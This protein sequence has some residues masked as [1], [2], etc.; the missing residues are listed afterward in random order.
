MRCI[1]DITWHNYP[2]ICCRKGVPSINLFWLGDPLF[3]FVI[4][5]WVGNHLHK[6]IHRCI[7]WI[8]IFYWIFYVNKWS[9][10]IGKLTGNYTH[11]KT[12]AR[13]FYFPTA[14]CGVIFT[15]PIFSQIEHESFQHNLYSIALSVNTK[16]SDNYLQDLN[17]SEYQTIK[18]STY[19]VGRMYVQFLSKLGV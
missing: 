10:S 16:L 15:L 19:C 6:L 2:K 14:I 5:I 11:L 9:F 13:R 4:F 18:L 1:A 8:N 3:L 17:I 7:V 12:S